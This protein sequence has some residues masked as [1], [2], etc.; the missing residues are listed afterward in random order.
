MSLSSNSIIHFTNSKEA[1][2]GI[3]TDNFKLA[4]CK[5]EILL[6]NKK[7][8]FAVPMVSFCDIPLS[9]VKKHITKYGAYGLGLTKEWAQNKKLNPVLYVEKESTLSKSYRNVYFNYVAES[10]KNLDT[11]NDDERS[12]IDIVRY[13]KNYQ[14]EIV[15]NET[16]SVYTR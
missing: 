14:N 15:D 11:I 5:E 3:L 7:L 6:D 4:Y 2:K 12:I 8:S 16:Q 1:L 13:I 9:Q 10:G